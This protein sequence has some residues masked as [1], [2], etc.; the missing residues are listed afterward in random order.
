MC[1]I[2]RHVRG[3]A[4]IIFPILNLKISIIPKTWSNLLF[5]SFVLQVSSFVILP[6]IC[7]R[8]LKDGCEALCSFVSRH[9]VLNFIF[10]VPCIVTLY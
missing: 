3:T 2:R 8:L 9:R 5:I 7:I 4:S 6:S 10:M 1:L